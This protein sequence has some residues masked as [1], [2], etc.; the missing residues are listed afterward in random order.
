MA[1][2]RTC[3]EECARRR[4]EAL[5]LFAFSS[6]NWKRPPAEV[7]ALMT[8]FMDAIDAEVRALHDNGVRIRFVGDRLALPVRLQS[9]MLQAEAL[10]ANNGGL[11]LQ[12]AV[13]YGGR[14][15]IVNASQLVARRCSE[16]A[17]TVAAITEDVFA[18]GLQL[19]GIP[20]PDLFIRTGG[21]HRISNFLLW[22]LAYTELYF[23]ELLWPDFDVR[24][25][26]RAL[27]RFAARERRYGLTAE[28]LAARVSG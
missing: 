1:P 12:L 4:I 19:A 7:S 15:D 27:A 6:E 25:L 18:A 26:E 28:Q 17:L 13:A 24:E 5:T 8:L 9:R 2:V 21:E 20:E 11:K 14:W 23:S 16:G 3:I 10:T 22:D